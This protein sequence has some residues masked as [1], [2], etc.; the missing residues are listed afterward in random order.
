MQTPAQ[1]ANLIA[2]QKA[3]MAE[4]TFPEPFAIRGFL[5]AA[6]DRLAESA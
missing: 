3:M 5:R 6:L 1:K 2:V 4:P